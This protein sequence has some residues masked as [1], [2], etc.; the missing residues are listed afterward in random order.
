MLL[1]IWPRL[2]L[3]S[4]GQ[5][6]R[7]SSEAPLSASD[8]PSALAC[9]SL[10][11]A[12]ARGE[13]VAKHRRGLVSAV[14]RQLADVFLKRS[15]HEPKMTIPTPPMG[16]LLWRSRPSSFEPHQADSTL[17]RTSFPCCVAELLVQTWECV[18][19][20]S[21]PSREPPSW[22][23]QIRALESERHLEA[24]HGV[25]LDLCSACKQPWL[26]GAAHPGSLTQR[27]ASHV[28]QI[29]GDKDQQQDCRTCPRRSVLFDDVQLL[30]GLTLSQSLRL[31]L[32]AV[33]HL[34]YSEWRHCLMH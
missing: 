16:V 22:R 18:C 33:L 31:K 9:L 8:L 6:A 17:A 13:A 7:A 5:A 27:R 19:G 14:A 23:K 28:L 2:H 29:C 21:H 32:R 4:E 30:T 11:Q 1:L 12:F 24:Q 20:Q 26:G 34:A 3:A 10:G 15:F 25:V